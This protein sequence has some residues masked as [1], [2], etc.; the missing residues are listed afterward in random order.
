MYH[1][2]EPHTPVCPDITRHLEIRAKKGNPEY[3]LNW[4][5]AQ[6]PDGLCKA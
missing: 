3:A 4:V 5:R 2:G 6:A 1:L